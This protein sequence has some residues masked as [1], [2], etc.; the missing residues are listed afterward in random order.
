MPPYLTTANQ[1]IPFGN[2]VGGHFE[3]NFRVDM[4]NSRTSYRVYRSETTAIT[5]TRSF[6]GKMSFQ[7]GVKLEKPVWVLHHG[8]HQKSA[9]F[10]G[11]SGGV[12]YYDIPWNTS[13]KNKWRFLFGVL[14]GL[15]GFGLVKKQWHQPDSNLHN[16]WLPRK[17]FENAKESIFVECE[18]FEVTFYQCFAK[19]QSLS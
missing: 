14:G 11:G 10:E 17:K 4:R 19:L 2:F 6:L 13:S 1:S 18:W 12:F 15:P 7:K 9:F 3:L 5:P 8:F 16:W